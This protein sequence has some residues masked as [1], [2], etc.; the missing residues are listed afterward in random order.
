MKSEKKVIIVKPPFIRLGQLLKLVGVI[1]LGSDAK[2]FL[3]SNSVFI[4]G[5]LDVRRGRK[6]YHGYKVKIMNVVYEV[7]IDENQSPEAS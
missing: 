7:E 3:M 5:E 6:I 1:D 4:N 2:H